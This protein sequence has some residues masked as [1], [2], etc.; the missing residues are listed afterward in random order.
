MTVCAAAICKATVQSGKIE[1]VLLAI[2]D[3][4]ITSGDI[5]YETNQSKIY[6]FSLRPE[7]PTKIVALGAGD[8]SSHD[9]I[10]KETHERMIRDGITKVG[11]V[12]QLYAESFAKLRRYQAE[13][14]H[15]SFLNLDIDSFINRQQEMDPSQVHEISDR[16][17]SQQLGVHTI[18]AGVDSEA[19][20]YSIGGCDEF[21]YEEFCHEVSHDKTGF[22][23]VGLGARQF[24]TQYMFSRYDNFWPL[25]SSVF[26]MYLAKKRSEVAP[27]VGPSTDM[28]YIDSSRSEAFL[29]STIDLLEQYRVDFE[30]VGFENWTRIVKKVELE[31][32]LIKTIQKHETQANGKPG[33]VDQKG[34][35]SSPQEGKPETPPKEAGEIK[36]TPPSEPPAPEPPSEPGQG[37]A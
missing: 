20:I 3:R 1:N 27:G 17:R 35:P 10:V 33:P 23:A 15:L 16:L 32:G 14:S 30:R 5:E 24:E 2:S 4:M 8:A 12:A 28:V 9:V 6:G 19:H 25:A 18:I 11:E 31:S 13:K 36:P 26:L 7:E 22:C 37:S 34:V 21:T 29:K